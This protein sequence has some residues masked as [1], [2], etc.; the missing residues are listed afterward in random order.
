MREPVLTRRVVRLLEKRGSLTWRDLLRLTRAKKGSLSYVLRRLRKR[1]VVEYRDGRFQLSDMSWKHFYYSDVL[2]VLKR[3]EGE[4]I[5]A[6]PLG[7]LIVFGEGG[8]WFNLKSRS[9]N[10]ALGDRI[11]SKGKVID[12]SEL[13]EDL[14]RKLAALHYLVFEIMPFLTI[15]LRDE[16]M[17]F[18]E[19]A[20]HL[21]LPKNMQEMVLEYK[22]R[23]TDFLTL[24]GRI[25]FK[26]FSDVDELSKCFAYVCRD[27]MVEDRDGLMNVLGFLHDLVLPNA[28]EEEREE[29][30]KLYK[31][32]V[33]REHI[34]VYSEYLE[35]LTSLPPIVYMVP[36][37]FKG[38]ITKAAEMEAKIYGVNY[39]K[40]I[41][42]IVG[43]EHMAPSLL[44]FEGLKGSYPTPLLASLII[45]IRSARILKEEIR[46]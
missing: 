45:T 9:L 26:G 5:Q 29:I 30:S 19:L 46:S 12:V 23:L 28:G 22:K 43:A 44:A 34:D 21:S 15:R 3:A 38:Y 42:E 1:G 36:V 10:L 37:G 31:Y 17:F 35:V 39:W 32:L 40:R 14:R 2:E 7:D 6:T 8:P 18:R 25:L 13:P 33:E 11:R 41:A 24:C 27:F 4:L 20:A 16:L